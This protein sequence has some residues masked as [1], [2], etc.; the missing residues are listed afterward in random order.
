MSWMTCLPKEV[1]GCQT[2]EEMKQKLRQSLQDYYDERAE[3]E[4]QDTLMRQG[5]CNARLH[6]KR[7]GA[8]KRKVSTRRSSFL[9]A[10]LGRK[11]LDAGGISPVHRQNRAADPRR[12]KARGGKTA[13][14]FRNLPSALLFSKVL[15]RRTRTMPTSLLPSAGRTG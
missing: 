2:L 7:A 4:V 12:R 1:G 11:G 3:M 10:Q 6:A 9:K 15:L 8:E 13:C 5:S 14:A